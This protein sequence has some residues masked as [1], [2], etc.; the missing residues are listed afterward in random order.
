[1]KNYLP[2]PL[3]LIILDGW[4]L[5]KPHKGN[6]VNLA[7]TPNMDY[8]WQKFPHTELEASGNAVGLPQGDDGNSETGHLNIGTGQIVLQALP[9]INKAIDNQTFF[10]NLAFEA[11]LKQV[12]KHY[13]QLHLIGLISSG[14]VHS[15]LEHLFALLKIA[16]EKKV[17]KTFLHLFTDG[18][19]SPPNSCRQYLMEVEKEMHKLGVGK[20]ATLMGRFYA[21][22]RDNRWERTQI[23]YEAMTEGKGLLTENYQQAI[24]QSYQRGKTDEFL[25]PL[26]I[27]TKN[28]RPRALIEDND[29]V[30]FFNFR[31][32]RPRQLTKAFVVSDFEDLVVKKASFDPY[33]ELFGQK[34]YQTIGKIS[35]FKRSKKILNLLFVTMTDYE[36]GLPVL[37]GFPSDVIEDCLSKTLSQNGKR[38]LHIAETEKERHVTYYFNGR[39]EEPFPNEDWVE[40]P[41]P[42]VQTYDLK[43]EMSTP[44]VCETVSSRLDLKIYDFI[45]V[46]FANPDM[47]GHTGVLKAGIKA[48]EEVDKCLGKGIKKIF[49]LNGLCLITADHG[50][51]EEMID[52]K[53]G[54]TD[55]KHSTNPV[56]FIAVS[57]FFKGKNLFLPKGKLCQIAPTILSLLGIKIPSSMVDKKLI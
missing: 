46:N 14:C 4:G 3:V 29:S 54:K 50:N 57:K 25:D 10:K 7:S 45:L 48:C 27:T 43:P 35:T 39:R 51:I 42:Q 28:G 24:E 6:A 38:Q 41:S 19:D 49:E 5:A 13:S 34:Q 18:R 17:K 55:T 2:K 40:I 16:A 32:D 52:L 21:M 53:T 11:A 12:K 22:D 9:Q 15:S 56:P 30:I 37:A 26:I 8:F 23:A 36:K 44:Q 1:M 20:I 31:I 47:V 33:A